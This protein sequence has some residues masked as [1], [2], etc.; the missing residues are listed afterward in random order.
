MV[1]SAGSGYRA[2]VYVVFGQVGTAAVD[3]RRPA[4]RGFAIR[5]GQQGFDAGHAVSGAGE[6]DGDGLADVAVGA[7]QSGGGPPGE[8][9]GVTFVIFGRRD[10]DAVS[11]GELAGRGTRIDG[12]HSFSS[13]GRRSRR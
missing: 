12:E 6:F 8:G 3:L 5:G 2:T 1:L 7:S 11:L 13:L 9:R 4:G 10:P